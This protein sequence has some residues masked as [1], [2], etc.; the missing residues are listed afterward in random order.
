MQGRVFRLGLYILAASLFLSGCRRNHDSR[1]LPS[2]PLE[3]LEE[4]NNVVQGI[5]SARFTMEVA[6]GMAA[7]GLD[8][9]LEM[10]GQ[11]SLAFKGPPFQ[12]ADMQMEMTTSVLGQEI[13]IEML[14]VNGESWMRQ[15]GQGWQ[16]VPATSVNL[17]A[18]LGGDPAAALRYLDQ[19]RDADKLD[20]EEIDGVDTYHFGFT[21]NAD[22]LG[23]PELLGQLTNTGQLTDTQARELLESAVLKGQVW[24]SKTDLFPRR[25]TIDMTFQISNLPG[26]EERPVKYNLQMDIAFS[27]I[28]EPVDI[29]APSG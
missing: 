3:A 14:A 6:I 28:N 22:V 11:G 2:N 26:L 19:A 1:Q 15:R 18:G 7:E 5:K 4:I 12:E 23:T 13:K 8:V 29:K 21:M 10:I 25:E 16:K 20:D 9:N 24:V 17:T 27:D